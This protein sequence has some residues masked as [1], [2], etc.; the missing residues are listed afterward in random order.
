MKSTRAK[1]LITVIIISLTYFFAFVPINNQGARDYYMLSV[2]EPDEFAQYAHVIRMT[3][4]PANSISQSFYRLFA[5]QHYFYGYPFYLYSAITVVFP[6]KLLGIDSTTNIILMLRQMVSVFPMLLALGWLT[7]LQ[8][9]F[10]TYW[11]SVLLFVF[12][13]TI[14]IVIINDA[15]WHPESLVFLFIVSVFYFLQKDNLSFGK[16]FYFAAIACGLAIATKLIGLF[17]FL[18]IPLYIMLGFYKGNLRFNKAIQCAVGFV[19]TMALAFV[20]SSPFLF[21]KSEREAAFRIQNRQAEAM[22]DGF[23]LSYSKGPAPWMPLITRLYAQPLFLLVA[24][25]A[26]Y[27]GVI[28]KEKQL[29]NSMIASWA[30]PFAIYLLF[31]ISVKPKHFFMP[32]LLPVFSTLPYLWDQIKPQEIKLSKQTLARWVL[33]FGVAG[34]VINQFSY[35]INYLYSFYSHELHKEEN[36]Q[37]LVFFNQLDEEYLSKIVLNRQLIIYRDVAVYIAD[38]SRWEV[39]H[40]WGITDYEYIENLNPDLIVFWKQRIYDYTSEEAQSRALEPGEFSEAVRFYKDGL[41]NS[42]DGYILLYEDEFGMAYLT[43]DL[44][45]EFFE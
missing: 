43:V 38:E 10:Q 31:F 42:I 21:Y 44:Y 28:N 16:N 1:V 25:L 30:I 40:R 2:F 8:T 9:K 22:S 24:G 15:W 13:I 4:Q 23:V 26:L 14:P 29:L 34:I 32:I 12:L 17:F 39:N 45:K 11:R 3:N 6:L 5:Y 33:M 18:T 20:L 41:E 19:A 36:N 37:A 7:F 35:N 27:Y